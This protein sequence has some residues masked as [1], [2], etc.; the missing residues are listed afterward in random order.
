MRIVFCKKWYWSDNDFADVETHI[1]CVY[2]TKNEENM[3]V[4]Q[5]WQKCFVDACC[6][7]ALN[8]RIEK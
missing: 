3:N 5:R 6:K 7:F 2:Q 8:C 1:I 4:A